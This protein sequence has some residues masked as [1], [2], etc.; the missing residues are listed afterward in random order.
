[1]SAFFQDPS[2]LDWWLPNSE[3]YT[4]IVR[5]I[6]AFV[7]SRTTQAVDVPQATEDLSNMKAIFSN[8]KLDDSGSGVNSL[9]SPADSSGREAE[10]VKMGKIKEEWDMDSGGIG[11]GGHGGLQDGGLGLGPMDMG[12]GMGMGMPLSEMHGADGW[13]DAVG[14][15][16][17]PP[18]NGYWIPGREGHDHAQY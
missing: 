11:I 6:R 17:Y 5:A 4:P 1:M 10:D 8:M 12:I 14:D 7:E 18:A 9:P 13:A 2:C 3:N 16:E 15:L